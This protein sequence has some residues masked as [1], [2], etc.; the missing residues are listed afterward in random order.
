MGSFTKAT[1]KYTF[2][3]VEPARTVTTDRAGRHDHIKQLRLD[4][5]LKNMSKRINTRIT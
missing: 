2:A 4:I 5:K 1:H 3:M